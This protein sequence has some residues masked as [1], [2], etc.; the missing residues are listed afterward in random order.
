LLHQKFFFSAIKLKLCNAIGLK[1]C[2]AIKKAA[3][4]FAISPM[5]PHFFA[6]FGNGSTFNLLLAIRQSLYLEQQ[7]SFQQAKRFH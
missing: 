6:V 2:A 7:F 3:Y 5:R 1:L 4:F